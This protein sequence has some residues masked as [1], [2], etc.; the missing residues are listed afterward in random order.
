MIVFSDGGGWQEYPKTSARGSFEVTEAEAERIKAGDPWRL[1]ATADGV[2]FLTPAEIEAENLQATQ[3]RAEPEI[4]RKATE[5]RG[6][7]VSPNKDA[8]YQEKAQE[9][10]RWIDAGRPNQAGGFAYMEAEAQARGV[11]LATVGGE[12][13]AARNLWQQIDPQI[14]A[15]SRAGKV[16][17]Q[18]A[19]TADEAQ[20]AI[21]NALNQLEALKP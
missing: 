8:T 7:Y 4:D 6:V 20:A 5:V 14:E 15:I 10:Q 13:E 17:A 3:Q 9:L 18:S 19:A 16:A 2:E 12:I 1:N 11:T 21:D